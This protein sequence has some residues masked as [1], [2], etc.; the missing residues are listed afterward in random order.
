V[1]MFTE[2]GSIHSLYLLVSNARMNSNFSAHR[3][4]EC[5]PEL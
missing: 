5:M 4:H 3:R 2:T 1:N